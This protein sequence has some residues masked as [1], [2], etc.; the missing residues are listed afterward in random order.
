MPWEPRQT[1]GLA[2]GG[3][4]HI[5]PDWVENELLPILRELS[6]RGV[7]VVYDSGIE[8]RSKA[9]ENEQPHMVL[10]DPH[11]IV[12]LTDALTTVFSITV[13]PGEMVSGRVLYG[14]RASDTTD[15]Q[16]LAGT[17][18]FAI[19]NKGGTFTTNP[20]STPSA[21]DLEIYA[22]SSGT[23][24]TVWSITTSG[25]VATLKVTPTGSLTEQLYGLEYIV[26]TFP[27]VPIITP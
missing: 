9:R 1:A 21:P 5:T 13:E 6:R 8:P 15:H 2:E 25:T 16:A 7:H 17:L 27:N 12:A 14:I 23:L 26:D 10:S 3:G 4:L 18:L 20:T 11:K 22:A 19:V 24:S